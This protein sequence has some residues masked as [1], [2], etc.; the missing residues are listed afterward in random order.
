MLLLTLLW[1]SKLAVCTVLC[2]LQSLLECKAEGRHNLIYLHHIPEWWSD[3]PSLVSSP[4]PRPF[5]LLFLLLLPLLLVWNKRKLGKWSALILFCFHWEWE[6]VHFRRQ[7]S[8]FPFM[9]PNHMPPSFCLI[10]WMCLLHLHAEEIWPMGSPETLRQYLPGLT[11]SLGLMWEPQI[12]GDHCQFQFILPLSQLVGSWV[13][14][15][16]A[17]DSIAQPPLQLGL[18]T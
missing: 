7:W 1:Q 4:P 16:T 2:K 12:G 15:Y 9:Y 8:N 14:H 6:T 18:T 5:F 10:F 11:L 13:H 17:R 3:D